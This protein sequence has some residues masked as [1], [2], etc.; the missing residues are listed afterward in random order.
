MQSQ[1]TALA[2]E[3]R[4]VSCK[5]PGQRPTLRPPAVNRMLLGWI[6][7]CTLTQQGQ[8]LSGFLLQAGSG[9]LADPEAG[10]YW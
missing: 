1:V 9:G 3:N 2:L 7:A 10:N 4:L 8:E 5:Q 6:G